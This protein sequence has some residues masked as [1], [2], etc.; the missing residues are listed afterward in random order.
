VH[1]VDDGHPEGPLLE[2]HGDA[3]DS[4]VSDK[5]AEANGQ[6]G[7]DFDTALWDEPQAVNMTGRPGWSAKRDKLAFE[8]EMLGALCVRSS[9]AGL[10]LQLAKHAGNSITEVL[11]GD[12]AETRRACDDRRPHHF[13]AAPDGFWKRWAAGSATVREDLLGE[14]TA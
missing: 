3:I 6:V 4:A 14:I 8:R 1:S 12:V 9:L 11:G 5:R 10:E 2:I 13:G 7:F